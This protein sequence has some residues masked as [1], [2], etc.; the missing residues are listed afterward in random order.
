[1]RENNHSSVSCAFEPDDQLRS[2]AECALERCWMPWPLAS[3][4]ELHI[5]FL[6]IVIM[7]AEAMNDRR[8]VL[9]ASS[10]PEVDKER[11]P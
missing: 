3:R 10:V 2:T 8:G 11:A 6:A 1:M 4:S 7:F 9:P 5:K